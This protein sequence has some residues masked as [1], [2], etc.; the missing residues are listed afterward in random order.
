MSRHMVLGAGGI[1]CS[2]A[3]ALVADGDDVTLVSRSGRGP[4]IPGVHRVA[5]DVANAPAL[6]TAARGHRTIVNALNPPT[7]THWQRDWPPMASAIL[8]AAEAA[9]ADLVTVSNLYGYG[10]VSGPMAEDLPLSATGTKGRVRAT[11]WQQALERHRAGAL[12][13]TEVRG[14]DYVGPATLTSS[15]ISSRLLPRV[16]AGKAVWM[17]MGSVDAPHS[18]TH[19]GDVAALVRALIHSE[20]DEDWGR[21]WHVP[22]DRAVSVREL[23]R[24]AGDLAG[25]PQV[26]VRAMPRAVVTVGGIVIP[27]L[28]ALWETRHQFEHPFILDSSAA[29]ERFGLLPTSL[30]ESLRLTIST[31]RAA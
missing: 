5:L 23:V 26:P 15:L 3:R 10:P 24:Q 29:Q 4:D 16:L 14:S 11:M 31:L 17:P 27:L 1:G 12:R 30:T 19:D 28:R 20:R 2:V 18:W 7:Y 21:A 9:G 6:A 13:V 25:V 22:T 8:A